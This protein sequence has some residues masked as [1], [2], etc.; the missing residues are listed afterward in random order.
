VVLKGRKERSIPDPQL[1]EE[2]KRIR[3]GHKNALKM[4]SARVT[5]GASVIRVFAKETKDPLMEVLRKLPIDKL[6]KL[7]NDKDF[8]KWF[9][10]A[11][12]DIAKVIKRRNPNR[13]SIYPGYKWGHASKVLCVYLKVVVCESRLFTDEEAERISPWLYTPID[14]IIIKH[15]KE[16]G[17]EPRFSRIK[18]IDSSEKFYAVQELLGR[19]ADAVGVPRIWFDDIWAERQ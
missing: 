12:K 19:A 7:R 11:L 4:H 1:V 3:D 18:E 9:E 2:F 6:S 13:P 14:S 5:L 8:S 17:Q 16:Q 15:L 10:D